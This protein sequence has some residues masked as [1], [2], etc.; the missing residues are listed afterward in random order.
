MQLFWVPIQNRCYYSKLGS[1]QLIT[2]VATV[3]KPQQAFDRN[4][5]WLHVHTLHTTTVSVA[6]SLKCSKK[7]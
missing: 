1:G 2:Q 6:D 3:V 7:N 4:G 5:V